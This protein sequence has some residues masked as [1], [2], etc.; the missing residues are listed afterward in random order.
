M[1]GSVWIAGIEEKDGERISVQLVVVVGEE[2]RLER[3]KLFDSDCRIRRVLWLWGCARP[4]VHFRVLGTKFQRD[5]N[6]SF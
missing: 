6:D 3:A 4:T 1:E 5:Q 2:L